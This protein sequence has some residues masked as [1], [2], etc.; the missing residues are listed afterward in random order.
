MKNAS[1]VWQFLAFWWR[2]GAIN[3]STPN[4]PKWAPR[5]KVD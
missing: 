2:Y 1:T 5:C 3:T 4:V